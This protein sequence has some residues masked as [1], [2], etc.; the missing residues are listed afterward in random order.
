MQLHAEEDRRLD[1]PTARCYTSMCRNRV[2][3]FLTLS[4]GGVMQRARDLF[5]ILLLFSAPVAAIAQTTPAV[6][7][8]STATVENGVTVKLEYTLKDDTGTVIDSNKGQE[9]LS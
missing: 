8:S 6:P 3:M 5:A 1:R 7:V 9:P 4:P 2:S